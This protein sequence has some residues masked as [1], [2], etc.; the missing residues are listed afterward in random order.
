MSDLLV[1]RRTCGHMPQLALVPCLLRREAGSAAVS[2]LGKTP[3]SWHRGL[4]GPRVSCGLTWWV[5]ARCFVGVVGVGFGWRSVPQRQSWRSPRSEVVREGRIRAHGYF[6][7][8]F[9]RKRAGRRFPY[10]TSR[11]TS[12]LEDLQHKV[13]RQFSKYRVWPRFVLALSDGSCARCVGPSLFLVSM[14]A[15]VSSEEPCVLSADG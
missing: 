15:A 13:L 11:S 14:W 1:D 6:L 12:C 5:Y 4:Y 8:G 10:E 7:W 3:A 2:G 9:V